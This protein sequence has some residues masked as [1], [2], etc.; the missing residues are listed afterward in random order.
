MA[1]KE[2]AS[3]YLN[4]KQNLKKVLIII[5]IKIPK[6]KKITNTSKSI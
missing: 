6:E 2:F 1:P 4:K 3:V 5:K